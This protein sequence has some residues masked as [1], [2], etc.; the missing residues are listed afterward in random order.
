M[1]RILI[2]M[3]VLFFLLKVEWLGIHGAGA[4]TIGQLLFTAWL[5]DLRWKREAKND[6]YDVTR[7]ENGVIQWVTKASTSQTSDFN[8]K[9]N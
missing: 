8:T 3:F 1:N 6:P 4:L 9:V 5:D 7:D 2:S